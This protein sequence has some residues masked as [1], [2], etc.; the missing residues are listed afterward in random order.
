[1]ILQAAVAAGPA[2]LAYL[3]VAQMD[4]A[5]SYWDLMAYDYA[6]SWLDFTANS[7]NVYDA[8]LTNV[9]TDNALSFYLSNGATAGKINMGI[10]L[11]GHAFEQTDGKL[12]DPYNGVRS[13]LFGRP[14][15]TFVY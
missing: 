9:S 5:L 10:P 4:M 8:S 1:M 6:G 2:N 12:G 7:A 11:Y 3:N 13:Y 15:L 14:F